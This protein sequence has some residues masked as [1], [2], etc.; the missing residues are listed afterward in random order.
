MVSI[1]NYIIEDIITTY[2]N[3]DIDSELILSLADYILKI[4][5]DNHETFY[6][7][8]YMHQYSEK[9]KNLKRP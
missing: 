8:G 2:E 9:V 5:P 7:L 4:T 3:K 6:N 1:L